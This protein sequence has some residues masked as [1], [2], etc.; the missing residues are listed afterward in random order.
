MPN[1]KNLTWPLVERIIEQHAKSVSQNIILA[2]EAYQDLLEARTANGGTDAL[3]ANVL[4]GGTATT[5]QTAMLTDA[6]DAMIALHEMYLA[7]T[8][9]AIT[10]SNRIAAFRRMI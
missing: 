10:T 8:N 6:K 4:F 5:E 7:M 3:F 9:S 1:S 2:E